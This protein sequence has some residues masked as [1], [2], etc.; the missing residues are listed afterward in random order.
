MKVAINKHFCVLT[1]GAM[2]RV[3]LSAKPG[4]QKGAVL[5]LSL[6]MLTV[7]TI[8]GLSSMSRSSLELKVANNSQQHNVAFQA[9]Q[10]RLAFAG[11]TNDPV[12]PINYLIAVN[13][14]DPPS[15]PIQNCNPADGCPNGGDWVAAATVAPLDCDPQAIGFSMEEGKGLARRYFEITATGE[16]TSLTARSTQ[17][18]AVRFFAKNC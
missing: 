2:P 9:A 10:S 13:F 16:T 17:V 3:A 7:L 15:W 6:V 14:D 11:N 1:T 4:R 8:I 5:V 12:N 18:S